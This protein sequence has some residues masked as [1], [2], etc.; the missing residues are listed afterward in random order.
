[1]FTNSDFSCDL[2]SNCKRLLKPGGIHFFVSFKSGVLFQALL[3]SLIGNKKVRCS[4]AP[5]S[6]EYLKAIKLLIEENKI[7]LVIQRT[8]AMDNIIEAHKIVE[9]GNN[10]VSIAILIQ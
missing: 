7:K 2:L 1:M 10:N 6:A 4:I 8:F 5:G 3:T 9:A